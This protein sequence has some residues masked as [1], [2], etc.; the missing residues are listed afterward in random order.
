MRMDWKVVFAALVT[1]VSADPAFSQEAPPRVIPIAEESPDS[2]TL[3]QAV[4]TI[5]DE[6]DRLSV[7]LQAHDPDQ[8]PGSITTTT[9]ELAG[10]AIAAAMGHI[11][12]AEPHGAPV[13]IGVHGQVIGEQRQLVLYNLSAWIENGRQLDPNHLEAFA[14]LDDA[15]IHTPEGAPFQVDGVAYVCRTDSGSIVFHRAP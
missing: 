1:L 14:V 3:T 8:T 5:A 12:L 6:R 11:V 15:K 2:A 7:R 13:L 9:A 4:S 10:Q